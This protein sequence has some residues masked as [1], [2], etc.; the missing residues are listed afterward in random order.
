M[1]KIANHKV[2]RHKDLANGGFYKK[3]FCS[4][5]ISDY[6]SGYYRKH[7]DVID[8][9]NRWNDWVDLKLEEN[10]DDPYWI[11]FRERYIVKENEF[12]KYYIK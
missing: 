6:K 8:S 4:Y 5:N 12:Y 9:N 3:I 1:K 2:A 7:Q 11:R 10:P